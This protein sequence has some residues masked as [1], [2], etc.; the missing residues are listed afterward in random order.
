MCD[1]IC[2]R[3]AL[4]A[5]RRRLKQ[6]SLFVTLPVLFTAITHAAEPPTKL[7][8]PG[9]TSWT[10]FR[11]GNQQLGVAT[12]PLPD[13]LELL[14]THKAGEMVSSTAAIVGNHVYCASLK[15]ETFCLDRDTGKRIWT[16]RSKDTTDPKAFI[17]GFKS[18]PTVTADALYLGDEE[19]VFH[20]IDRAT[21]KKKW[22]FQTNG[23]IVS[24]A[25]I[26]ED[27]L[28][29]GSYDNSL[30]CLNISDGTKVWQFETEGMV[31]CSP[32]ISGT[33]TFVTGCDEHLRIIDILT[34]KQTTDIPLSTYL[35]ASPAV[36]G[37]ILYVGTF[38]SEV[39]AVDWKAGTNL[40]AYKDPEREF[41]YHSSAAV[42]DRYVVV[43]GQDKRVH[44][45]NR[46]TGVKEW[47]FPTK[48]KVNSSPVIVGDRVFVGSTDGNLYGL[49][50]LDGKEVFRHTDG[51][52][53]TASPA[54]GEGV[55]VIGSESS[56]GNIY[57]F[58][59]K[60]K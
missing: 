13:K 38:A 55:L 53:F 23:E 33:S 15:G 35:I 22:T 26:F 49:S 10:S 14:W 2:S 47:V 16:Y 5:V 56:D 57:C 30:Y 28:L 60:K 45:M 59:A 21:G 11:N 46:Q 24:S 37:N 39:L 48:A 42:S 20:A 29:F 34:G 51:R 54:I 32:A 58:G 9:P 19:G 6:S 27:K 12:S 44:C 40:W 4:R 7:T 17:P 43:G 36:S 3:H 41:P 18:S 50:L 1:V 52:P 8:P 31:N 25:S